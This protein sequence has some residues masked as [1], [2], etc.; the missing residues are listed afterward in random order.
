MLWC[1]TQAQVASTAESG[2]EFRG[3]NPWTGA[4]ASWLIVR[5]G[6]ALKLRGAQGTGS[7]ATFEVG[8]VGHIWT[9][10]ARSGEA[11]EVQQLLFASDARSKDTA[12]PMLQAYAGLSA[13]HGE[14]WKARRLLAEAVGRRN[15]VGLTSEE[16]LVSGLLAERH[17]LT[18]EAQAA[19]TRARRAA[20]PD[21]VVATFFRDR[22]G[23]TGNV[24]L[25]TTS[26]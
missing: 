8:A 14:A 21:G 10:A 3:T 17:G 9:M 11:P 12:V 24:A 2:W 1:S 18:E 26:R 5:E 13:A 23:Q 16:W 25:G 4:P 15:R 22:R 6:G 19:F 20:P 7:S